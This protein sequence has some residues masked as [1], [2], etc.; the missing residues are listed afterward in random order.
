M[1][2]SHNLIIREVMI[3]KLLYYLLNILIFML[4]V[5]YF[6]RYAVNMEIIN[7]IHLNHYYL[8]LIILILSI[9]IIKYIRLISILMY[10]ESTNER[11]IKT[12]LKTVFLLICL[13]FKLGEIYRV[14]AFSKEMKSF[15]K[16]LFTVI[17]DRFFDLSGLLVVYFIFYVINNGIILNDNII[18]LLLIIFIIIFLFYVSFEKTSSA[19][20]KYII[21]NIHTNKVITILKYIHKLNN[22]YNYINN[23]IRDR[24]IFLFTLSIIAWFLEYFAIYL[25]INKL[26]YNSAYSGNEYISILFYGNDV[27]FYVYSSIQFGILF[28]ALLYIYF[29]YN[30]FKK[31][32]RNK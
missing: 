19:Y 9:F 32:R 8:I 3:S 16:G 2:Q 18:L 30:I 6:G 4:A 1:F 11:I 7:N 23:I 12:Y 15:S 26:G 29:H 14:Y 27:P 22:R 21:T 17:I 10:S 5:Y 20:R 25:T 24:G 31:I 28:I 13:P